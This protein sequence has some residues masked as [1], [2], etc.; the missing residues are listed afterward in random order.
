MTV[1]IDADA[2]LDQKSKYYDG[3]PS[4]IRCRPSDMNNF[5][6][7]LPEGSTRHTHEQLKLIPRPEDSLPRGETMSEREH[8]RH[9]ELYARQTTDE[10]FASIDA[11]IEEVG[12]KH[13]DRITRLN[14]LFC[15]TS[16]RLR[17]KHPSQS[18]HKRVVS[19]YL[20]L[21]KQGYNHY[22]LV[23]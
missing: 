14:G 17:H 2:S 22:D 3:S 6:A 19:L 16:H 1:Q 13:I 15:K 4:M 21:R 8:E 9:S 7:K 10:F 11:A 12:V 23:H 20:H 18:I 5:Y